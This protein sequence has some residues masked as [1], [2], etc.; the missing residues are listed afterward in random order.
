[1]KRRDILKRK[2]DNPGEIKLINTEMIF[3]SL[4]QLYNVLSLPGR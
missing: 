3:L 1:M 2:R 4:I